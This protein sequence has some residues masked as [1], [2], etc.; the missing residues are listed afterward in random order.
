MSTATSSK[1]F[2]Y[3]KILKRSLWALGVSACL[4]V[5]FI[6]FGIYEWQEGGT[7]LPTHFLPEGISVIYHNS[8]FE[9]EI[10]ELSQKSFI[11]LLGALDD[12]TTICD[13][14]KRRDIALTVL[15][16]LH[17]FDLEKAL[18]G[19]FPR[20][21][22]EITIASK[23]MIF[24]PGLLDEHYKC[25]HDFA[26]VE[27][28][29]ITS[30]G[31][32]LK[33]Q[34]QKADT[35]L[36]LAFMQTEEY[37]HLRSV[38]TRGSMIRDEELLDVVLEADWALVSQVGRPRQL[39]EDMC[40][41][42]RRSFLLTVMKKD[43][44]SAVEIL[45]S[46]DFHFALRFLDDLEAVFVL[47]GLQAKPELLKQFALGLL[48][49]PR[50]DEVWQKASSVLCLQA[51]LN[52]GDYSREKLLEYFGVNTPE[53]KLVIAPV[54]PEKPM[55]ADKKAAPAAS[56]V[57]YVVQSGDSL[58]TISKKFRV[59]IATIKKHNQLQSDALKPG[60]KLKIPVS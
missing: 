10:K 9:E 19:Y 47:E 28:W 42:I 6:T 14:Y 4:N 35:A 55:I 7:S 23:K 38:F 20:Q 59:D 17:H 46:S 40:R 52:S 43:C 57:V 39:S 60:A 33:L 58:W 15:S 48:K 53:K 29:P 25:L 56:E 41:E 51:N 24:Y 49:S 27:K 37:H 21:A 1:E 8:T 22:R 16:S 36:R 3:R 34:G 13:G 26:S 30:Q 18:R 54:V 11:E 5:V 45:V 32:F 12:K 44:R 50:S 31:L 2:F